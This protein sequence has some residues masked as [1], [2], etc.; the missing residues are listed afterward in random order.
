M[1]KYELM[2]ILDPSISEEERNTSIENLKSLIEKNS[3][4]IEKEDIWGE[5]TLAYKIKS[6]K[7]GFYILFDIEIDCKNIA[8]YNSSINLDNNIW[9]YMFVKKES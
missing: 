6:S 4:K 3:W 9:R 1:S 8:K 7:K 2:V 5:K